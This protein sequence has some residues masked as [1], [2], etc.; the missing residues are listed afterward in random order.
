MW[1][2][3]ICENRCLMTILLYYYSSNA[4]YFSRKDAKISFSLSTLHAFH[5]LTLLSFVFSL[6][7]LAFYLYPPTFLP[8]FYLS[9]VPSF[10]RSLFPVLSFLNKVRIK[11]ELILNRFHVFFWNSCSINKIKG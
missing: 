2:K 4:P 11:F 10:P 9:L 7:S 1:R 8:S 3:R 5:L 6:L